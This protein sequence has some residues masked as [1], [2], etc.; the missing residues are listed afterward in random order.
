MIGR[1]R[2]R[3]AS[4]PRGVGGTAATNLF[5]PLVGGISGLLLARV[6]GPE[7][8]G[9]FAVLQ[10]VPSMGATLAALG[11]HVSLAYFVPKFQPSERA[12]LLRSGLSPIP[13][14]TA[15]TL[16]ICVTVLMLFSS[17]I[18][19]ITLQSVIATAPY[20]VCLVVVLLGQGWTRGNSMFGAW[21]FLR[22]LPT[23]AW[24]AAVVAVALVSP[25][26]VSF[27]V[28]LT[29]SG[30]VAALA[31][32][33][34]MRSGLRLARH[35][36]PVARRDVVRYGAW[37]SL[38]ALPRVVNLRL[39][40]V[41]IAALL[42]S[43]DAGLYAVAVAIASIVPSLGT[44]LAMA[45]F[46][47]VASASRENAYSAA[48]RIMRHSAVA[49]CLAAMVVGLATPVL[50]SAVG[51]EFADALPIA[52]GWVFVGVFFSVF[53]SATEVELALGGVRGVLVAEVGAMS[54]NIVLLL[55]LLP[56]FGLQGA[57]AAALVSYVVGSAGLLIGLRRHSPSAAAS[58]RHG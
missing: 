47:E 16:T 4:L 10:F 35:A 2:E 45:R 44:T 32:F 57:I 22:L 36:E 48:T 33:G 13:A 7:D 8:R 58:V 23:G 28:A 15:L 27:S 18:D 29:A 11:M 9:A 26:V 6:L 53:R 19:E 41:L 17:F 38:T 52:L 50:L 49:S 21:N 5:I 30:C 46:S 56:A 12:G 37:S 51:D 40:V 14:S 25:T 20:L 55:V 39:D 54:V 31:A 3:G 42:G 43:R 24:A 1:I 34:F